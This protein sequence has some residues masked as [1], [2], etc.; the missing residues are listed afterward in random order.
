M[1]SLMIRKVN[2]KCKPK[3]NVIGN[4]TNY[5]RMREILRCLPDI[6]HNKFTTMQKYKS[7]YDKYTCY[8]CYS[9]VKEK[10]TKVLLEHVFTCNWLLQ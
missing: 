3:R 4:L 7:T 8:L 10:V 2:H 1:L 6:S 9:V 5:L